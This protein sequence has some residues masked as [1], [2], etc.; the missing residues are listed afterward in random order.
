MP[1]YTGLLLLIT[2]VR[3]SVTHLAA[4]D[5]T[6]SEA[7]WLSPAACSIVGTNTNFCPRN[8]QSQFFLLTRAATPGVGV[9][10]AQYMQAYA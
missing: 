4:N 8:M 1:L 5:Y 6:Q 10:I 7:L 2:M 9:H 3:L